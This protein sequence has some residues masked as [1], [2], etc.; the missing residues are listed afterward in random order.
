MNVGETMNI[1]NNFSTI[2]GR[3][4]G[5]NRLQSPIGVSGLIDRPYICIYNIDGERSF[6]SCSSVYTAFPRHPRYMDI[7]ARGYIIRTYAVRHT[8]GVQYNA[9]PTD[10][11]IT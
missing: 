10:T 3:T 5:N 7:S 6:A 4:T 8:G 1:M 9:A 2:T 11:D